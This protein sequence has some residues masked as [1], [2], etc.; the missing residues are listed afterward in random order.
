M[1]TPFYMAP[2]QVRGRSDIDI[3]ADIYSLGATFYHL[4]T[5]QPPFLGATHTDVLK[6][7]LDQELTPPDHLNTQLSAGLGEVVEFM[8]AKERRRRYQT[9]DDLILDLECLLNG[10]PPRLA[11]Q[12]MTAATLKHLAEGEEFVESAPGKSGTTRWLLPLVTT[13]LRLSMAA[14]LLQLLWR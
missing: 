1:G 5:G 6:A 3:R 7:H 2:E 4:V 11:R 9:P 12:R 10:E 8:M 13:A 14:N